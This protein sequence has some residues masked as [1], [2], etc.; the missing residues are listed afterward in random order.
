LM[1]YPQ[2]FIAV[3]TANSVSLVS[4]VM[5]LFVS[6]KHTVADSP[7]RPIS[8]TASQPRTPNFRKRLRKNLP[9]NTPRL[10]AEN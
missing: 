5:G 7:T 3:S 1:S 10:R 4:K 2:V 6:A 8:A 9:Q